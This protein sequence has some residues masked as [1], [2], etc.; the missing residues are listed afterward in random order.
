[1]NNSD[2]RF[3]IDYYFSNSPADIT[4]TDTNGT[5]ALYGGLGLTA[6]TVEGLISCSSPSGVFYINAGYVAES[7]A[8]P[9]ID[10]STATW[11]KT[12]I[13][14]PLD[15]DGNVVQGLY[16]FAYKVSDDGGTTVY[17]Y[18]KSFTLGLTDPAVTIDL[19]MSC[20]TSVLTST[21][22]SAY[23]IVNDG[24]TYAYS[25]LTRAHLITAPS[26]SL[27]VFTAST[28]D[29]V[30]TLGGG[31]TATT[32]MYTGIWITSVTTDV[33]YDIEIWDAYWIVFHIEAAGQDS[34][35]VE[36]DDCYCC[37]YTCVTNLLAKQAEYKGSNLKRYETVTRYLQLLSYNWMLYQMAAACGESTDVYCTAMRTIAS[38]EDCTCTGTTDD[39]P[40]RVIAWGGSTGTGTTTCCQWYS[41]AGNA[42]PAASSSN[43]GSFYF[44]SIAPL[45]IYTLYDVLKSDGS[46]WTIVANIGGA[47]G[48]TTDLILYSNETDSGTPAGVGLTTLM[49]YTLG[50]GALATNGEEI[51]VETLMSLA[52]NANQKTITIDWDGN[53][54]YTYTTAA[55]VTALD[56]Y[57]TIKTVIKR[58]SVTEQDISTTLIRKGFV[59]G[60]VYSNQVKNL[61]LALD[62]DV[63]G[64]NAVA[65]ANDI[66]CMNMTVKYITKA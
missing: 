55:L 61:A 17:T 35:D 62:I 43:N 65:S 54:V 50:A 26:G 66:V 4:F 45:G 21:D 25:S 41:G 58:V 15:A 3:K 11:T 42:V 56:Q 49:T 1:M 44:V 51:V 13:A 10:G 6:A 9:D 59:D 29:A 5:G 34:I 60:A 36:C 47:A 30:R 46:A 33:V 57:L 32:D 38:Y 24:T 22:S 14:L 20:R 7:F 18:S 40:T 27:L 64:Q 23:T 31:G 37:Y 63:N 12:T 39:T 19:E 2:L 28:T 52:T 8:A 16:T 48:A 53:T